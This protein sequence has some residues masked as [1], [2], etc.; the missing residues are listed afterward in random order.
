MKK[1]VILLILG[2]SV[3]ACSRELNG[4]DKVKWGQS[5]EEVKRAYKDSVKE[6]KD[7]KGKPKLKILE[8]KKTKIQ[9]IPLD[10]VLTFSDNKLKESKL[11]FVPEA[12]DARRN[13]DLVME[14]LETIL[15]YSYG[16]YD[17]KNENLKKPAE[18][19][20]VW[21]E[22]K[23]KVTLTYLNASGVTVRYEKIL[24][25]FKN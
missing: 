23:S 24:E 14:N 17:L 3:T 9:E 2:L 13:S 19:N 18:Y 10:V 4:W 5:I 21:F 6:E 11:T 20:L 7:V 12:K 22:G 8:L 25:S 16:E 1:I 15:T